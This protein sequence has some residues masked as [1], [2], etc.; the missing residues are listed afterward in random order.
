MSY[1]PFCMFC[2]NKAN[3]NSDFS[4]E[5]YGFDVDGIVGVYSCCNCNTTH[6]IIDVFLGDSQPRII[7]YELITDENNTPSTI[8]SI[9]VSHCILCSSTL[10][11]LSVKQTHTKDILVSNSEEEQCISKFL[12]CTNCKTMYTLTD[13]D[14]HDEES[15][16]YT[17][18]IYINYSDEES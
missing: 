16:F 2:G 14:H 4:C 5:D 15:T 17:K 10:N 18:N 11:L 9:N 13:I 12:K 6:Y 3:W 8:D 7:K 1:P